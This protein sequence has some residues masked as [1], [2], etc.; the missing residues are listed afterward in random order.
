MG[1]RFY[2]NYV[3]CKLG[4]DWMNFIGSSWFYINYVVC[5][6]NECNKHELQQD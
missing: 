4:D 1:T 5:K 2:I 3:V 6:L